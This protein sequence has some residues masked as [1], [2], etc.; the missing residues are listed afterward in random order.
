MQPP[1][2][3]KRHCLFLDLDGTLAEIAAR[4]ELARVEEKMKREVARLHGALEGALAVVSGRPISQIDAMLAPLHLPAAGVHGAERRAGD[5]TETLPVPDGL[6]DIER[7]LQRFADGYE[8][9]LLETKAHAL[10]LHFRARPE[11]ESIVHKAMEEAAAPH[12]GLTLMKGKMV[13]EVKPQ[14]A[15]KGAA[16]H[17]FMA[18]DPFAGR[19]PVFAGDDVTDEDGFKAAQELGGAGLKIGSGRTAAA[20]RLADIATLRRWLARSADGL[21]KA[22]A[23]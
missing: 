19:I 11:L 8:G 7:A 10:C 23:P 12:A 1:L 18:L 16:V 21:E 14:A 9:V 17:A 22:E 4:P 5:A 3:S 2:L 13:M 20:W 6:G 15:T